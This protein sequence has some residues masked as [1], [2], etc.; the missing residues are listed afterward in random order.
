MKSTVS[1][2]HLADEND[3]SDGIWACLENFAEFRTRL[4][5]AKTILLK[6]NVFGSHPRERGRTTDPLVLAGIIKCLAQVSPAKIIIADSAVIG[7]DTWKAFRT[8]GIEAM[9]TRMS[10]DLVDLRSVDH[11]MKVVERPLAVKSVGIAKTVSD[12]DIVINVPKLKTTPASPISVGMKN[13]K[14]VLTDGQKKLFHRVGLQNALVDLYSQCRPTFTIVDGLIASELGSPFRANVLIC[15]DDG[16]AV[17]RVA[18]SFMGIEVESTCHISLAGKLGLG[19]SDL[20]N[21]SIQG[22]KPHVHPTPFRVAANTSVGLSIP[23]KVKV[24]DGNPCSGCVGILEKGL[25]DLQR[26]TDLSKWEEEIAIYLGENFLADLSLDP[27]NS[28]LMGNCTI[29][30]QDKGHWPYRLYGCPPTINQLH[31]I[32]ERLRKGI[33]NEMDDNP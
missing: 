6:P 21:I 23:F 29:A 4:S 5:R 9:A 24:I 28:I 31:A 2:I 27:Q 11:P 14:G 3:V 25:T 32:I 22:D 30:N 8:T 18:A 17:D 13:L 1:V 26:D 33:P 12:A 20:Q 10:A 19:I 7:I 15:G 16:V